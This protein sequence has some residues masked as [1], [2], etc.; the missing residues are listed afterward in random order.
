MTRLQK[1]NFKIDLLHI[2]IETTAEMIC[3]YNRYDIQLGVSGRGNW[4]QEL[5][6]MR[7]EHNFLREHRANL[8]FYVNVE[9]EIGCGN[10]DESSEY[11][12]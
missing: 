7:K 5:I 9:E 4:E 10:A 6:D 12:V 2:R 8:F 3:L 11:K 1:L